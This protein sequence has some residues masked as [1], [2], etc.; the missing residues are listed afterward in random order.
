MNT[1]AKLIVFLLTLGGFIFSTT[2]CATGRVPWLA[3]KE[4][5]SSMDS[6]VAQAASNIQYDTDVDMTQDYQPSA[7][8]VSSYTTPPARS[9]SQSSGGGGGSCCH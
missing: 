6:Y 2:G 8:P 9:A 4:D 1:K 7:Q 5:T 3:K